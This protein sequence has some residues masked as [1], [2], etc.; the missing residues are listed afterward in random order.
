MRLLPQISIVL[1]KIDYY[2][3]HHLLYKAFIVEDSK[4][5]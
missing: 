3:L 5:C 1:M 4:V 2:S